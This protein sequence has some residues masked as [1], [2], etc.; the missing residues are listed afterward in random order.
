MMFIPPTGYHPSEFP[1]KFQKTKNLE[2][3][4]PYFLGNFTPK[5][6]NPVALKIGHKRLSRKFMCTGPVLL[7]RT[8]QAW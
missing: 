5:T 4:V 6:S 7:Y 1:I 2:R 8:F 3:Q